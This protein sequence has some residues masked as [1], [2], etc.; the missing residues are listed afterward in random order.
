MAVS[1]PK[2]QDSLA[3]YEMVLGEDRQS[4]NDLIGQTISLTFQGE[5]N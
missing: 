5:I 1:L 2:L 4:M 3:H